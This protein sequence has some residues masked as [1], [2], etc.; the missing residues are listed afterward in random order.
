MQRYIVSVLMLA[1]LIP[2]HAA[3]TKQ[4]DKSNSVAKHQPD[5]DARVLV[6]F[7]DHAQHF[8]ATMR[9]NLSDINDI[10]RAIADA[11]F[12]RAAQI[13]EFN[14]GLGGIKTHNALAVDMPDG[15]RNMGMAFH[16][17]SSQLAQSLQ[18][19]DMAKTLDNL[20]NVSQTCVMCHAMY[21]VR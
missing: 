15:M 17:A 5:A 16:Q 18:Q 19:K 9:Q 12:E 2:A 7:P 14:L 3:E 11:N 1:V 4:H 6:K 13:A 10:H 20:A 8:L 21:R